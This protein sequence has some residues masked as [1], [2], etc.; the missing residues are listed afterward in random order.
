VQGRAEFMLD[1]AVLRLVIL[2]IRNLKVKLS[3]LDSSI[4][5]VN[6][7]EISYTFLWFSRW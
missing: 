2:G 6:T 3:N 7:S 1:P 4:R 5:N